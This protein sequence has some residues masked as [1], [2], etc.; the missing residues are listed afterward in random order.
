MTS[1]QKRLAEE[2]LMKKQALLRELEEMYLR[3]RVGASELDV[4]SRTLNVYEQQEGE[5]LSE[6]MSRHF[7][8]LQKQLQELNEEQ[9][10]LV[11]QFRHIAS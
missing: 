3:V 9:D 1:E 10:I 7:D 11:K 4:K 6:E 5:V 8:D 2:L